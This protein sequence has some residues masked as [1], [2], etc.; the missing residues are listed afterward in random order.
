MNHPVCRFRTFH[1]LKTQGLIQPSN[2]AS[3]SICVL[4]KRLEKIGWI[5]KVKHGKKLY[6]KITRKGIE[7]IKRHCEYH[8]LSIIC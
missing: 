5:Q 4:V 1:S 7:K 3:T 8:K 6:L 2:G